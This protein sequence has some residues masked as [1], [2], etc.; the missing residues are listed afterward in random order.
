MNNFTGFRCSIFYVLCLIM[1]FLLTSCNEKNQEK[2]PLKG[3]VASVLY[4]TDTTGEKLGSGVSYM[5]LISKNGDV[6]TVKEK[7]LELNSIIPFN[8]Q[9]LLHQKNEMIGIKENGLISQTDFK[10]CGVPSGYGQSSGLLENKGYYYSIFNIGFTADIDGYISRIRW[11]D[12]NNNYCKELGSYIEAIGHDENNIYLL[13][14]DQTDPMKLNFQVVDIGN[15]TVDKSTPVEL[16]N[17]KSDSRI[18]FTRL[19]PYEKSLIGIFS[20]SS[21]TSTKLQLLRIN[22]GHPEDTKIYPLKEYS[23]G[24]S[25]Y[26]LYNKDSIHVYKGLIYYVDGYGDVYS[27]DLKNEILE[28]EFHFEGYTRTPMLQDEQVHFSNDRLFFFRINREKDEHQIDTYL[29]NG[30]RE[31]T[32]PI[33]GIK[34]V[35]G[36][37]RVHIY[38]F[39]ILKE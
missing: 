10:G 17:M 31:S 7:G 22:L 12:L 25:D 34:Q 36:R 29:L 9:L 2:F 11:G 15:G 23:E 21:L 14:A 3:T 30:D 24:T 4:S 26:F 13:S 39:K 27:Y 28:K 20:N 16:E 18:I 33:K 38:D 1:I 5:F 32:V 35:I 37:D 19:V 6:S 8:N